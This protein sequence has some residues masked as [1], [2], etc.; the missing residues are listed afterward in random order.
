MGLKKLII[1]NDLPLQSTDKEKKIKEK[2]EFLLTLLNKIPENNIILFSS[3]NPDKRWKFYKALK[4]IWEIKEF[5]S[6]WEDDIS[7]RLNQK[8]PEKLKFNAIKE[9][10]KYKWWHIDKII[11]EIDKLLI[12]RNI[13][14]KSD[15]VEHIYPE[16]EESIFILINN[17]LNLDCYDSIHKMAIILDTVNIHAF[18]ANL[19]SN[20][21]TIFYIQQFKSMKVWKQDTIKSLNLWKRGFLFDKNYRI[22]FKQLTKLYVSLID[23][24]SKMKTWFM[25]WTEDNDFKFE[26][27]KVFISSL[28]AF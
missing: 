19:L 25:I 3:V 1:I 23:L 16:L 15:I 2:E 17:I 14:S 9:I 6:L 27:E 26:I 7:F 11:P 13:I 24:D 22:T 21:R 18:Y 5:N 12:T 20:L 8:Y 28:S 10:I 4:K